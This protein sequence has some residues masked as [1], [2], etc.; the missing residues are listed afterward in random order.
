MIDHIAVP[1]SDFERSKEFYRNALAPLNYTL[2]MEHGIS[3]AGFGRDNRPNFWIQTKLNIAPIHVAFSG[4][5]RAVVDAFYKAALA[6]GGKDNG[7]PGVRTEYH[8]TYYGAF[9]TDPDGHNIEAVCHIP[10]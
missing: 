4:E 5:S 10:E 7:K 3:G 2:I 1:V 6:A 9:I 8:P